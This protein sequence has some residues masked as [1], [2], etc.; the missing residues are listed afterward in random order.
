[1][2]IPPHKEAFEYKYTLS[3]HVLGDLLAHDIASNGE[4]PLTFFAAHLHA[5]DSVTRMEVLTTK[6][7]GIR[8]STWLDAN[9]S[10]Y[11]RSQQFHEMAAD[12][13]GAKFELARGDA[14]TISCVFNTSKVRKTVAYGVD[15]GQEMCGIVGFC[16]CGGV[17]WG[18]GGGRKGQGRRE[19]ERK[20]ETER[21]RER[22][23]T[24]E[25]HTTSPFYTRQTTQQTRRN[26][27]RVGSTK[28]FTVIRKRD[29][30]NLTR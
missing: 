8:Y 17:G 23:K 1:M 27:A 22:E 20:R 11:G 6:K 25:T 13:G 14:L 21:N 19:K 12:E 15:H 28:Q 16:T 3:S 5:H 10:G 18:G 7:S 2:R 4:K 29:E 26:A 9:Y 24:R 30:S